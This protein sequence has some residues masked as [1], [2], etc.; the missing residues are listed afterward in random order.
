[1]T[2]GRKAYIRVMGTA[3]PVFSAPKRGGKT[4]AHLSQNSDPGKVSRKNPCVL[5]GGDQHGLFIF[6]S[7]LDIFDF[8]A[9]ADITFLGIFPQTRGHADNIIKT[10]CIR[11][12]GGREESGNLSDAPEKSRP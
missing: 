12:G 10:L 3:Q 6:P 1:M 2:E 8:S 9:Q 4:N 5:Q 7:G 11:N